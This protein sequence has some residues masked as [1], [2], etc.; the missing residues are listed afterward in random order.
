[1][2]ATFVAVLVLGARNSHLST[3][4]KECGDT[5]RYESHLNTPTGASLMVA[6]LCPEGHGV[7]G[8]PWRGWFEQYMGRYDL[9]DLPT[10]V[11]VTTTVPVTPVA[12]AVPVVAA[13][14]M[15]LAA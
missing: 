6:C 13:T 5:F 4:V 7:A 8:L 15:T 3:R 12:T 1:M 14:S 2:S 9:L 11:P 10:I